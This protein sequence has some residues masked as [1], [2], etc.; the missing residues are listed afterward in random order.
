MPYIGKTFSAEVISLLVHMG[1]VYT[2]IMTDLF[3][4]A[5]HPRQF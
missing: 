5:R 2:H 1:T 4:N 3:V